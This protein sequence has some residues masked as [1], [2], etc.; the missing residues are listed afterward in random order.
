[1]VDLEQINGFEWDSGNADKNSRKHQVSQI[2]CEEL[3]YNTPII[4][5]NDIKHSEQENRYYVLGQTNAKRLLF[6]VFT[7]RKQKIRVIS[8]RAMNRKEKKAYAKTNS[9]I[10]D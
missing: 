4:L 5:G 7:V 9:K 10:S 8:A 2:E 6:I 3:F 1:M